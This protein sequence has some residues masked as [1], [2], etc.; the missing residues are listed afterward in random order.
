MDFSTWLKGRGIDE[1]TFNMPPGTPEVDVKVRQNQLMGFFRDEQNSPA[2][3]SGVD[4]AGNAL[5]IGDTVTITLKV[6]GFHAMPDD[7]ENGLKGLTSVN[8]SRPLGKS[9]VDQHF[10]SVPSRLVTKKG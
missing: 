2:L 7:L 10:I 9:G 1:R 8:L 3:D 5:K 4:A 6:T